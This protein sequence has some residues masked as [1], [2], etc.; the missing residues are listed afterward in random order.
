M[1]FIE[2]KLVP[3]VSVS[4]INIGL[5][6]AK[7]V[8]LTLTFNDFDVELERKSMTS[9]TLYIF[10]WGQSYQ[11]CLIHDSESQKHVLTSGDLDL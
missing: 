7:K 9:W 11:N 6:I 8:N 2:T 5:N 10:I 3:F 4:I 1:P